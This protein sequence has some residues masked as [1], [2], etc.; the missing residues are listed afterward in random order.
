MPTSPATLTFSDD[1]NTLSLWNSSTGAG[2]WATN[3]W[4]ADP[5]GNGSTLSGNGEQQWYI[6]AEYAPTG[7][8]KPWAVDDG[9]LTI[10]ARP[11]DDAI[12]PLINGYKYTSGEI[13]SFHTFSQQYG[14][15]EMRADLPAGQGAWP[16]FWLLP[17]NGDWPPELDVVETLGHDTTTLYTT[18]HSNAT[19][20][21][22]SKGQGTT[23]TDTAVGFHTYAVD[24]KADTITW[25]YDGV[26]VFQVE[27]PADMHQPMYMVANLAVGG[28]WPGNVN[29]STPIP[30]EMKIDYIHVYSS[31]PEGIAPPPPAPVDP[32][33]SQIL[34]ANDKSATALTGLAGD[35]VITA[36]HLANTL[37]GGAGADT[38][39][40]NVLPW[41]AGR[42][43]DFTVGVDKLDFSGLIA[44]SGYKGSNLV[45]D[46][47]LSIVSDGHGGAK[48]LFDLDGHGLA[49]PWASTIVTLDGVSPHGLTE[50][51][52]F[53]ASPGPA[54]PQVDPGAPA[55]PAAPTPTPGAGLQ[56]S[57]VAPSF[58]T[59]GL[60]D[61]VLSA[62]HLADTL[63]GGGGADT[64]VFNVLPWNAG[65]ITDF[66]VGVDKIDLSTL[67]KGSGYSGSDLVA[68]G[69]LSFG[70]DGLGGTKV[71]F[72]IDGRGGANP[73]ATTIT[74]LDG[75]NP[76]SLTA[77][78][79]LNVSTANPAAPPAAISPPPQ[80]GGEQ[81]HTEAGVY[82]SGSHRGPAVLTGGAGADTLVGYRHADVLTGGAGADVFVFD[83]TPWKAG[84]VT[85]FTV[86]VDRLD[87]SGL[88]ELSG[89]MGSDPIADGYLSFRDNGQGGAQVYV[90]LDG[91][92]AGKPWP[93]LIT[94]LD[95][96]SG[97]EAQGADW[98]F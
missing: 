5:K 51:Q 25:Y 40:F 8:V 35:D 98:L 88:R 3:F 46:G 61:D 96:V 28:Y 41:N 50:S 44:A 12:Q 79:V 14:Y 95:N 57:D 69:Y 85:D 10:T 65:H 76:A 42:I 77:A 71:M 78:Q 18:V 9:V 7:S 60:G 68:D 45:A 37:T 75:V 90:D 27:T 34:T 86:G 1:F 4:Y 49:T 31:K 17:A 36:A 92:G 93:F 67:I 91:S 26:E 54:K 64:F 84:H 74:T 63:T 59:G 89:Y 2:T 47:Y 58:L 72:D 48:L 22:T 11:A 16:A 21:H 33:A 24:W 73:W 80:T 97:L 30:L 83:I 32:N 94:T 52:L 38:F 70:S 39:V 53:G 56:G 87:L 29:A 55:V 23:V 81:A 20:S 13:N 66:V 15:F 19:G 43:T 82:L 6:N 62:A